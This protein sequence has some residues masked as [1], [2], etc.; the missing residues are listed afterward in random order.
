MEQTAREKRLWAE[1]R[2][3]AARAHVPFL[4]ARGPEHDKTRGLHLHLSLHLPN[5]AAVKDVIDTIGRLTGAF[6]A[7]VDMRGRTLRSGG[8]A[9]RGVV[10]KS[11]CGGWMI[12]RHDPTANGL[13]VD[14][15]TYMAKGSGK[16]KVTG[17]HRLSNDLTAL[18]RQWQSKATITARAA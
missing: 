4:A 11:E 9:T 1:L 16:S 3:V 12:Q 17:Q 10:A 2:M 8:R 18:T 14:L 5:S 7:W 13:S 6:A 15:I